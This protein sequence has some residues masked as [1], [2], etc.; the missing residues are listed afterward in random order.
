MTPTCGECAEIKD[1]ADGVGKCGRF[2][3]RRRLDAAPLVPPKVYRRRYGRKETVG[4]CFR[5][6][7]DNAKRMQ[8]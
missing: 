6:R 1:V 2:G 4:G 5:E 3:A 8:T 7:K